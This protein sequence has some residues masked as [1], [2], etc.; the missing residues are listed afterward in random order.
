MAFVDE[1]PL[2]RGCGKMSTNPHVWRGQG[3][4]INTKSA[5]LP[6]SFRPTK[7]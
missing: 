2:V 3:R 4:L 1:C 6:R 5:G 7:K